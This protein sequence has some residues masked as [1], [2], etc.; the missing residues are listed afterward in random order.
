MCVSCFEFYLCFKEREGKRGAQ[1]WVGEGVGRIWEELGEG[2][3]VIRIYCIKH[4]LNKKGKST[5]SLVTCIVSS[6]IG[7]KFRKVCWIP[8]C[9]S[10]VASAVY[11]T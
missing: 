2:E 3:S 4:F 1:S 7:T 8:S 5:K 11:T 9:Y 10:R 6:K